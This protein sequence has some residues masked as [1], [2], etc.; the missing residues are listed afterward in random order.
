MDPQPDRP[1]F[2]CVSEIEHVKSLF[3]IFRSFG[4]NYKG[5]RKSTGVSDSGTRLTD[6]ETTTG[7]R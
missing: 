4:D 7:S 1:I 3:P 6:G 2:E 5:Y